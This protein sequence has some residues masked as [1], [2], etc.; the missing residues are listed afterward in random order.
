VCSGRMVGVSQ[1]WR[2]ML[3]HLSL[4]EGRIPE[5]LLRHSKKVLNVLA[6]DMS[7]HGGCD[8]AGCLAVDT[9]PMPT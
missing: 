2:D 7:K 1:T 4:E 9:D 6:G 5:L 3:L 8:S